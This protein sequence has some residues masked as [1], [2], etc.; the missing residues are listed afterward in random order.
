MKKIIF[1]LLIINVLCSCSKTID[2]TILT[3]ANA[4]PVT[5]PAASKPVTITDSCVLYM[6]FNKDTK[7]YST[8]NNNGTNNGAKFV[9][10]RFG[11]DSSAM[12][13]QD[14]S[15]IEVHNSGSLNFDSAF[16]I[17]SWVYVSPYAHGPSIINGCNNDQM[18]IVSKERNL[19][20]TGYAYGIDTSGFI[21]NSINNNVKQTILLTQPPSYYTPKQ[22]PVNTWVMVSFICD[23]TNMLGIVKYYDISRNV[24][25]EY[26][27]NGIVSSKPL[28]NFIDK[29]SLFIGKEFTNYSKTGGV[30]GGYT[31][32]YFNGMIDDVRLYRK[33]LSDKDINTLY[34]LKQ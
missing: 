21:V 5:T 24:E 30:N 14:S 12:S 29:L 6:P 3:D 23:G 17:V 13:F 20:G 16:S 31:N 9:K 4:N 7:D 22:I 10:D 25:I 32:R 18:S 15:Y 19:G 26:R 1:T 2:S 8:Y 28:L 27:N 34:N 33:P 11:R